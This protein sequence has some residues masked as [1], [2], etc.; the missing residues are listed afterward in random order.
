LGRKI[1]VDNS[2]QLPTVIS[3]CSGYGGIE[4]G[5]E[6]AGIEHR[7]IAYV[8]IE[9]FAIG[10][11]VAKMEQGELVPAPIYTDIK[12][13]PSHLFRDS[14]DIITGGYPCQ[15]F[16]VAGRA[17]AFDDPRH[18]FPYILNH[19]RTIRPSQCFF[20]NVEGHINRGLESVLQD[21]EGAGYNSTW[22]VFSAEEVGAPH[23]RKRIFILANS[24][25][26]GRQQVSR[27][28]HENES[29]H[30][31]RSTA[32]T[33]ITSSHGE[34]NRER[35]L[36]NSDSSRQLQS[37]GSKSE[38]WGWTGDS[39]QEGAMAD[40][41]SDDRGDRSS[42]LP[43]ERWPWLEHRSGSER[44]LVGQPEETM[45]NTSSERLQGSE[46]LGENQRKNSAG[47]TSADGSASERGDDCGGQGSDIWNFE[48]NVGRMAH[49]ITDRVDRL[50]LLGNGVVPQTAAKA[51]E[52]LN[53][54][55]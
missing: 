28:A 26:A 32:Q 55:V 4:R 31:G 21:L 50:R 36:A 51:W 45:A 5:L 49:G 12:T 14:V 17:Q 48:P 16:S 13:F 46:W 22:G 11:L 53:G 27:S 1:N 19:V 9:A 2:K 6:L 52:V 43:R 44:Q 54:R 42:T 20:E 10:N 23:Q 29:E 3:F 30:E 47:Q 24:S 8:E 37:Q 41:D 40:P 39:G 33:D 18:L 25:G 15:P 38:Q 34:G 7:V 35:S